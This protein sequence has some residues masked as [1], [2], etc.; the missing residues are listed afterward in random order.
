MAQ[1]TLSGFAVA[2]RNNI[3]TKSET[4]TDVKCRLFNHGLSMSG[5]AP[6]GVAYSSDPG[7]NMKCPNGSVRENKDLYS[8]QPKF[9]PC[10]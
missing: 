8:A 9:N 10:C 2:I 4:I 7:F 6:T 3:S 5:N 1:G